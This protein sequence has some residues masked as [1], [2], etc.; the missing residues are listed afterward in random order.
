VVTAPSRDGQPSPSSSS[1]RGEL[2]SAGVVPVGEPETFM[3]GITANHG[4]EGEKEE[5]DDWKAKE[6][7]EAGSQLEELEVSFYR[8]NA[9]SNT[10]P[11]AAA[12]SAL[13]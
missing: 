11:I 10:L 7:R 1:T 8:G 13:A 12:N 9:L 2:T 5:A 6:R 3:F 4:D